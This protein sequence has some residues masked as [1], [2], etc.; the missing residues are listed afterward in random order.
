MKLNRVEVWIAEHSIRIFATVALLTL[1]G[2]GAF[3]YLFE[4]YDN[5]KTRVDVLEH[6]VVRI[7][8]AHEGGHP[9]KEPSGSEG[10]GAQ[11]PSHAGQQPGPGHPGHHGGG[12]HHGGQGPSPSPPPAPS[13][14]PAPSPPP[15]PEKPGN[16]P[17]GGSPPGQ[18]GGPSSGA[19]V[20]VCVL[21]RTCVGVEVGPAPKGIL[22]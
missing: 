7:V 1:I 6:R 2:V 13:P 22:P 3:I 4:K 10:G 11:N 9:P 5:T 18:A 14:S 17:P 16:G 15:S 21:E 12:N 20:E 19:G 8:K